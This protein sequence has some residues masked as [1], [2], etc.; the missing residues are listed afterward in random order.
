MLPGLVGAMLAGW[1][2]RARPGAACDLDGGAVSQTQPT[3][4]SAANEENQ[5]VVTMDTTAA[6]LTSD[7]ALEQDLGQRSA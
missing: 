6:L 1:L 2:L 3:S 7:E 5:P 4:P